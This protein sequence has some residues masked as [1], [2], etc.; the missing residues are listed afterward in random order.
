MDSRIEEMTNRWFSETLSLIREKS[1]PPSTLDTVI[2]GCLLCGQKYCNGLLALLKNGHKLP[3]AAILRILF[4]LGVK[5]RWCLQTK[6]KDECWQR[7]RRWN[8]A[9]VDKN[10]KMFEKMG[11]LGAA[12]EELARQKK[13][14]ELQLK[15]AE[16]EREGLKRMPD[17]AGIC[18]DLENKVHPDFATV[19]PRIYERFSWAVHSDFAVIKDMVHV[20]GRQIQSFD[21]PPCYCDEKEIEFGRAAIGCDMNLAVRDHYGW[22]SSRVLQEFKTL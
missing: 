22:D 20:S 9:S 14:Q 18:R 11:S 1:K 12:D 10:C 6:N 21:D 5:L 19:Y 7:F 3:A 15:T 16:L 4:E 17:V 2:A 13:V 8:Y